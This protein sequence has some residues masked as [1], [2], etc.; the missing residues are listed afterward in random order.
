[1]G[2]ALWVAQIRL[3][4]AQHSEQLSTAGQ[5][6]YADVLRMN[7]ALRGLLLEPPS[8]GAQSGRSDAASAESDL[9]ANLSDL[10]RGFPDQPALTGALRSFRE[11]AERTLLP[12][13][14]RVM[15]LAG[16]DPVAA[17]TE[18]GKNRAAL[19]DQHEALLANLERELDLVKN[20]EL[21]H[22]QGLF[23]AGLAGLL[24]IVITALFLA[25]SQSS[26]WARLLYHASAR[27]ERMRRGDFTEDVDSEPTADFGALTDGF[28]RLAADL[29]QLVGQVQLSVAEVDAT[30]HDLSKTT[31]HQQSAA[32]DVESAASQAET[33]A[34]KI[35]A[36]SNDLIHTIKEAS[37]TVDQSWQLAGDGQ[38]A[39]T[40]IEATMSQLVEATGSLEAKLGALSE[41]AAHLDG[42]ITAI[43]KV[44]D[45]TNLLS[46]NA[47]IE[48]EKAGEYGLGFAVVATE[49]RR[50]SDQ[51]AVAT[52]DLEKMIKG[53]HGLIL[54]GVTTIGKFSEGT[55][56]SLQSLS[57]AGTQL[58]Q[59]IEQMR[60]ISGQFQSVL[61]S[62]NAQAAD[63]QRLN[64]TMEQLNEAA[65]QSAE[66]LRQSTVGLG[67][68]NGAAR[69]LQTSVL[70]LARSK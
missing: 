13:D 36:G 57:H 32:Q 69:D 26:S 63:V 31:D 3:T 37:R 48:A 24:L 9:L 44:A 33:A 27:V 42:A 16:T 50:L 53:M 52:N 15:E 5:R 43:V 56:E 66:T 68:L 30:S 35:A 59:S 14:H 54:D 39:L 64:R 38:A 23:A 60:K 61:E 4:A 19:Q 58:A 28:N 62:V 10:Q 70:R 1:M 6:I 8:E 41:K 21:S 7:E 47:A 25:R 22:A 45:Q 17:R 51:T 34:G 12:F 55:R 67:K 20:S 49:I 29:S 11:F 18:Y 46:L 65:R 2:L 40:G